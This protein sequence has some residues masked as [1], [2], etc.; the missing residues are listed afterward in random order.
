[1]FIRR[2]RRLN[3][4][5]ILAGLA[6][7]LLIG[8]AIETAPSL[9]AAR[10]ALRSLTI[11]SRL[12]SRGRSGTL[13]RRLQLFKTIPSGLSGLELSK[14]PD[15][16]LDAGPFQKKRK[17]SAFLLEARRA[18]IF[19]MHAP[20]TCP[21][22][23][24]H[25][26]DHRPGRPVLSITVPEQALFDPDNGILVN[27]QNKGVEWEHEAC[28]TFYDNTGCLKMNTKAGLRLHGG[29]S[30][31]PGNLHSYRLHFKKAY[32]LTHFPEGLLF[33]ETAEPVRQIVLWNDWP[34][35][36][37]FNTALAFDVYRQVGCLTPELHPVLLFFNGKREGLYYMVQRP[38]RREWISH[39]GHTNFVLYTHKRT[40]DTEGQARYADLNTWA[41]DTTSP[42]T[43][44]DAECRVDVDYLTRWIFAMV[45]C[46]A[47][48][49]YQ[50]PGL[51]DKTEATPRWRWIVWDVDHSFA[52]IYPRHALTHIWEK[53]HWNLAWYR[54]NETGYDIFLQRWD[55]R[56]VIFTRL[57]N[58]SP[59]YR[60]KFMRLVTDLLNHRIT[61]AFA[62][63]S[64]TNFER[65]A[66]TY[67]FDDKTFLDDYRRFIAFRPFQ[68]RES[69]RKTLN[70][71]PTFCCKVAVPSNVRLL[72]DGYPAPPHYQ[73]WYFPG[74]TI[75]VDAD[76]EKSQV[77]LVNNEV[78]PGPLSLH[79]S[80]PLSITWSGTDH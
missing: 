31:L 59:E 67:E 66:E 45:F 26:E 55:I 61:P 17:P 21:D 19:D 46:G 16:P 62:K 5:L 65:L 20:A 2:A 80:G 52:R 75:T 27:W 23:G 68:L 13:A 53:D 12:M 78:I 24:V 25:A 43:L 41:R 56:G 73:G 4:L 38:T 70:L 3:I 57:I 40:L 14:I 44:D 36:V 74:Q 32:G 60:K 33:S 69:L 18:P 7:F 34:V 30:R 6:G 35:S 28:V 63:T 1:M 79:L 47:S 72:V 71:G 8:I 22:D 29:K 76:G 54:P 42:M 77:W 11:P 10:T 49:A 51:I 39:F 15:L 48:D 58:E 37:P 64:M 9:A 50:G